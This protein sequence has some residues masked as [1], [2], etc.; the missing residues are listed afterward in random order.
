MRAAE[1]AELFSDAGRVALELAALK[2]ENHRLRQ[3]AEAN[4]KEATEAAR[5][6]ARQLREAQAKARASAAKQELEL[7][8][9]RSQGG[10]LKL[11][12]EG[13]EAQFRL[14]LRQARDA[15]LASAAPPP[16][17]PAFA[18]DM[19]VEASNPGARQAMAAGT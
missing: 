7:A 8:Q 11:K 9:E 10:A 13:L 16:S 17:L 18:A 1:K 19:A 12:L 4:E 2:D 14:E 6:A 5:Q 3:E 15:G